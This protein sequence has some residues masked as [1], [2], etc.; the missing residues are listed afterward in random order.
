LYNARNPPPIPE[1]VPAP[2]AGALPAPDAVPGLP[3]PGH[4][5]TTR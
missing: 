3:A 4:A 2:D 5:Q 1:V